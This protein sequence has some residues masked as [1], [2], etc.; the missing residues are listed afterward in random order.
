M[1][2]GKKIRYKLEWL[3]LAWLY[4]SIQ[5]LPRRLAQSMSRLLG[6]LAFLADKRGRTTALENLTLIFG[7]E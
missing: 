3:G 5:L 4:F 1:S 7:D 2:I 6:S